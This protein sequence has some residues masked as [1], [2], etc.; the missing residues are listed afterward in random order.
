MEKA[1][2]AYEGKQDSHLVLVSIIY[3]FQ[4]CLQCGNILVLLIVFM[5]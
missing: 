2:K 4:L 5:W 3:Y 1:D